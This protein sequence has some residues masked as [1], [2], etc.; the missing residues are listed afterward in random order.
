M[1]GAK[2]GLI[3]NSTDICVGSHKAN[4]LFEGHNGRRSASKPVV[5]ASGCG[6]GKHG[7]RR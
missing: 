3:V 2:K 4:A 5:G 7:K 6:G 1:Q